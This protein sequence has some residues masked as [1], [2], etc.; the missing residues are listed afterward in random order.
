MLQIAELTPK[1]LE[2]A[3]GKWHRVVKAGNGAPRAWLAL[4]AL[5]FERERRHIAAFT[6]EQLSAA[7]GRYYKGAVTGDRG[8]KRILGRL[9]KEQLR[10]RAPDRKKS[11]P[12]T[13]SDSS[14]KSP[15]AGSV[16]SRSSFLGQVHRA[17]RLARRA[18]WP[19]RA[20][21]ACVRHGQ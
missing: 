11:A 13:P 19:R 3:I 9:T 7:I 12:F 10:R 5:L 8:A 2:M 17:L 6:D 21:R 15:R 20:D 1:Q 4:K 14:V 16:R 18:A